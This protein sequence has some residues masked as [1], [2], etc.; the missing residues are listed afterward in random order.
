MA[1]SNI[2]YTS[3]PLRHPRRRKPAPE[4]VYQSYLYEVTH[5]GPRRAASATAAR[6][7]ISD[8]TVRRIVARIEADE[9]MKAQTP[10]ELAYTPPPGGYPEPRPSAD[11]AAEIAANQPQPSIDDVRRI[12]SSESDDHV[13]AAL[14]ETEQPDEQPH[15]EAPH[16]RTAILDDAPVAAPALPQPLIVRE[17]VVVRVPVERPPSPLV[18]W[19]QRHEI[20]RMQLLGLVV[21][22]VL[23][24]AT[25]LG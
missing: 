1:A 12:T 8:D 21:L 11:F 5:S 20:A 17:R 14:I 22:L 24:G 19:W 23:I 10:P 15:A 25:W 16:A 3:V 18:A 6:Y 4:S 13:Q 7:G 2:P 9:Q